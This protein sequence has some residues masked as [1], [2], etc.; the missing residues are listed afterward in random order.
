MAWEFETDPAFQLETD[1]IDKFVR[2]EVRAIELHGER[3]GGEFA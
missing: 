3:L 1:G 2:E